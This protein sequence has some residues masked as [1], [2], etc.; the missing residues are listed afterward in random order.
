MLCINGAINLAT[1]D[2]VL[3]A[4]IVGIGL[5][6]VQ[7]CG[8]MTDPGATSTGPAKLSLSTG[9]SSRDG[10]LV[11][12]GVKAGDANGPRVFL[13]SAVK[14]ERPA[15]GSSSTPSGRVSLL[16]TGDQPPSSQSKFFAT[17][18]SMQGKRLLCCVS[19][20]FAFRCLIGKPVFDAWA[21]VINPPATAA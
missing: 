15:D 6:L 1:S 4:G 8:E 12:S 3:C 14:A 9:G 11:I 17:D 13:L 20:T 2:V 16:R 5:I 18:S 10:R 21:H 19:F 7:V